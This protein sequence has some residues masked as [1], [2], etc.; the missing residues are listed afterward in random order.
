MCDNMFKTNNNVGIGNFSITNFTLLAILHG[1]HR[2]HLYTRNSFPREPR[3]LP[4]TKRKKCLSH[5]DRFEIVW[6]FSY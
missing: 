5:S 3:Y 6:V 2:I 4:S 1:I